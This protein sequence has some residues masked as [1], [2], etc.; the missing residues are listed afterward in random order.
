MYKN[1]Y[2]KKRAEKFVF[3]SKRHIRHRN[4][5]SG[6]SKVETTYTPATIG[7]VQS[8]KEKESGEN[9]ASARLEPIGEKD[10]RNPPSG[11]QTEDEYEEAEVQA[12]FKMT[13]V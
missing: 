11:D 12:P 7:H 9:G 10:G 2:L 1:A 3:K 6:G 13:E 4:S 5:Q 8:N